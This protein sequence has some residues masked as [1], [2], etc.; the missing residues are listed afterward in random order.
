MAEISWATLRLLQT[1]PNAISETYL[2]FLHGWLIIMNPKQPQF[3]ME[4]QIREYRHSIP[5]SSYLCGLQT[6]GRMLNLLT[7][8]LCV[9]KTIQYCNSRILPQCHPSPKPYSTNVF[10][11]EIYF[12]SCTVFFTAAKESPYSC[13]PPDRHWGSFSKEWNG[14]WERIACGNVRHN[15][16]S[17]W[18]QEG[19]AYSRHSRKIINPLEN[20]R[21]TSWILC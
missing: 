14:L 7:P 11:R 21:A 13:Q 9:F 20:T 19:M 8:S 18:H 15:P 1:T 4:C 12:P 16:Q 5:Q 10:F 6:P 3:S 2:P 17:T